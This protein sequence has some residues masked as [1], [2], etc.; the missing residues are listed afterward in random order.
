MLAPCIQF[1]SYTLAKEISPETG[2]KVK[3]IASIESLS[4]A[5][6]YFCSYIV[7]QSFESTEMQKEICRAFLGG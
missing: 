7:H 4:E 3:T 2:A 5:S 6:F 1:W